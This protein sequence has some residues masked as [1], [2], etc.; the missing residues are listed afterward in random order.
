MFDKK[1]LK[2][3]IRFVDAILKQAKKD[4]LKKTPYW[5]DD[6]E[7]F[8]KGEWGMELN[9]ILR[10]LKAADKGTSRLLN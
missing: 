9:E 1:S 6:A 8:L 10:L 2:P 3:W 7:M 5:S 4:V